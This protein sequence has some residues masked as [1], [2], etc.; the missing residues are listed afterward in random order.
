VNTSKKGDREMHKS[1]MTILVLIAVTAVG[2]SDDGG[3]GGSGNLTVVLDAEETIPEGLASDPTGTEEEAIVDGYGV[4]FSRYIVSVGFVDMAQANGRNRQQ[5]SVIT[6]ADYV[7]LPTT[8]PTLDTFNGIQTGQYSEFGFATPVFDASVVNV[9][10]VS[11]DDLQNMIDNELTY[12]IAG[13]LTADEGGSKEFLIEADVSSTY[14]DCGEEPELGVNVGSNTTARVTL[15]GDH[16]FFNGFPADE[17]AVTRLAQWMWDVEDTDMDG[18]LTR[19]DFEAAT[20]VGALYPSPPY[21]GLNDGPVGP[22]NNAWDFIR[23]QLGTQGHLNGEGECE[24]G[25]L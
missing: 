3:S 6:V 23:S 15:H 24:W 7:N 8:L 16:I 1:T 19:V 12:I 21:S 25:P 4:E 5:S 22:I 14:T 10:G 17:T 13:T 18:V 11:V 20:D 9:N 2:C